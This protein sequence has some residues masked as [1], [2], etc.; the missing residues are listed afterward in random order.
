MT[1]HALARVIN[2]TGIILHA[3]LAQLS[4]RRTPAPSYSKLDQFTDAG[5]YSIGEN[6]YQQSILKLLGVPGIA[7]NNESAAIFLTLQEFAAGGEVIVSR[8]ELSSLGEADRF[9]D[10]V[11]R[12][13]AKLIEV[14][15]ADHTSTQDYENALNERTRLI[16]RVHPSN[17]SGSQD[18]LPLLRDLSTLGRRSGII[19][20]EALGSGCFTNLKSFGLKDEQVSAS[21]DAGVDLVSF[22]CDQLLGGPQSSILA[23]KTALV[24]KIQNSSIFSAFQCSMLTSGAL[25]EVLRLYLDHHE[26]EIPTLWMIQRNSNEIKARAIDLAEGIDA[27]V[28]PGES[29]VG[30]GNIPTWLI[31]LRGN[32]QE[33][34][35]H[36]RQ[37]D[38]PV[39]V[40][41]DDH[42]AI[43]DLRTVFPEEEEILRKAIQARDR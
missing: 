8:Q 41:I 7:V 39:F 22:S 14:S 26:Q 42:Q 16:L 18:N 17:L 32:A 38:P 24:Q 1:T 19:V 40:R 2:A 43:I 31:V 25:E 29:M 10:V 12:T 3:E 13:G 30:S 5:N 36:F 20:Y 21:L 11:S 23:G 34:D 27:E 15:S 33:W 28:I 35:K 37:N 4:S 6:H 9:R